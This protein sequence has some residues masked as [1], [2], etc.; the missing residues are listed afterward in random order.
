MAK[1]SAFDPV[2]ASTEALPVLP[3]PGYWQAVA[4]RLLRDRVTLAVTAIM[5]AIMASVVFFAWSR[6]GWSMGPG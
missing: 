6:R 4:Q 2:L 5:L 3:A 1:L